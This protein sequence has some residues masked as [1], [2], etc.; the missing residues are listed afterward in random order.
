VNIAIFANPALAAAEANAG[1][2]GLDLSAKYQ[3]GFKN[4]QSAVK[5]VLPG[6]I[7]G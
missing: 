7:G 1:E 6:G 5:G 2:Q 4:A 3:Q